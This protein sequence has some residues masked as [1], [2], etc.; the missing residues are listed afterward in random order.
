HEYLTLKRQMFPPTGPE[1]FL[2]LAL[3]EVKGSDIRRDYC[4]SDRRKHRRATAFLYRVLKLCEDHRMKFVAKIFVKEIGGQ[5]NGRAM[6]GSA[7]QFVCKHFQHSL[8]AAN[9]KGIMIADARFKAMNVATS[10]SVFTRK[11]CSD[12]DHFN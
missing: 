5:C 7:V 11:H 2:D 9:S 8:T 6:Y 3:S 12:G 10:H 4:D 1:R